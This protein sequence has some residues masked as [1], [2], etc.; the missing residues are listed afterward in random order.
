M[1]KNYHFTPQQYKQF[2]YDKF[3]S[4]EVF[5]YFQR[6]TIWK[7]QMEPI[8]HLTYKEEQSG[9]TG[10]WGMITGDEKHINWFLLNEL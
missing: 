8:Y 1:I 2:W 7:L 6:H 9:I 5:T 10:N 4:N 3:D